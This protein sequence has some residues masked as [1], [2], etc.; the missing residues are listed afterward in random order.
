M[1]DAWKGII[2]YLT[3]CRHFCQQDLFFKREN[4]FP[5]FFL[6]QVYSFSLLYD[7]KKW[8]QTSSSP[9]SLG[10]SKNSNLLLS[11]SILQSWC[12]ERTSSAADSA[13]GL[14]FEAAPRFTTPPWR[15]TLSQS[16]CF[17]R[18]VGRRPSPTTT[19]TQSHLQLLSISLNAA[20]T[21][22]S[23]ETTTF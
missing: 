1:I 15:M 5:N 11:S 19:T 23:A 17:W 9:T 13:A 21:P 2:P 16:E 12:P 3:Y 10:L 22:Q 7:V 8:I 14:D 4:P 18:R 20:Y 6:I